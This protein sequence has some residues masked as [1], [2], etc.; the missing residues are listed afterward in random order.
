MALSTIGMTLVFIGCYTDAENPN[1]IHA[2]SVNEQTGE[3]QVVESYRLRNAIYLVKNRAGNRLYSCM[4]KKAA[5]FEVDGARLNPLGSVDCGIKSLCHVS[6][7]RD[8]RSLYFADYS[9]SSCGR[10]E[11]DEK[12]LFTG[13]VIRRVHEDAPGPEKPRQD[14]THC[15]QAEP[16]PDGSVAVCDL[17]TDR[18]VL[19]RGEGFERIAATATLPGA[20]PRH[21]IFHPRGDLAFILFELG[22]LVGS[23]RYA[24]GKFVQLDM[25]KLLAPETAG[26]NLAAAIRFSPDGKM[27]LCSNRGEHSIVAFAYKPETGKLEL[28]SRSRL[29]GNWPRDFNFITPTLALATMERSGEVVSLRYNPEDGSFKVLSTLG[30]LFKPVCVIK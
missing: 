2:L 25:Q 7:S 4:G 21:L 13:K 28:K 30:S 19:Y 14:M 17:G 20:G 3:M 22:N 8:E 11:L 23:Y 18:I 27:L 29:P 9:G 6:L 15:H 24:E 12:G 26:H 5:V 16:A 10:A 1:G